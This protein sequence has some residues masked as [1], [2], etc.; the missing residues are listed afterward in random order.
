VIASHRRAGLHSMMES[1]PNP[2]S[3]ASAAE[4]FATPSCPSSAVKILCSDPLDSPWS[5]YSGNN[6]ISIRRRSF[7]PG[8]FFSPPLRKLRPSVLQDV[9]A[10]RPKG[11]EFESSPITTP[12]R[13]L[14]NPTQSTHR[15]ALLMIS[16]RERKQAAMPS[17]LQRAGAAQVFR[18]HN[19]N[20][21]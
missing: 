16:E 11:F 14:F 12:S 3:E 18:N 6:E 15:V 7:L 4:T 8:F 17:P 9:P 21:A 13:I 2:L 10:C 1:N 5:A 19:G 20:F